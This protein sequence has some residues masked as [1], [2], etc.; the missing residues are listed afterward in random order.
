M[1]SQGD[2]TAAPAYLDMDTGAHL[3]LDIPVWRSA[4]GRPLMI[5]SLA[6]ITRADIDTSRRS[7]WRYAK[8]LP[9][10]VADP[11]SLGEG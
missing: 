1:I 8:S 6:G 9:L 5:T 10:G 3:P 7:L 4:S 2:R 11:I